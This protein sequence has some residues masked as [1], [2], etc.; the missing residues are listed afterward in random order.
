MSEFLVIDGTTYNIPLIDV[1]RSADVLD[2]QAYRTEDGVLHRKVIGTYHNYTVKVGIVRD[3]DLYNSLFNVLSSPIESHEVQLPGEGAPQ[4][5][6]ISS[7]KD[8]IKRVLSDG[9]T[10]YRDLSF[11]VTCVAPTRRA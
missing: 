3:M 8:G 1:Q 11:K 7:V 10:K 2:K 4:T 5:R 6:Y 9:V